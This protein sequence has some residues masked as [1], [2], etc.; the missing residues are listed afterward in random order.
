MVSTLLSVLPFPTATFTGARGAHKWHQEYN[1]S[2]HRVQ[3]SYQLFQKPRLDTNVGILLSLRHP[4]QPL[5]I[6]LLKVILFRSVLLSMI[7]NY[8]KLSCLIDWQLSVPNA[9]GHAYSSST[10]VYASVRG[11]KIYNE[12]Y[13]S[14]S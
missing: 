1:Y 7:L 5:L 14:H 8:K 13:A 3:Y 4:F 2:Y 6:S 10:V 12:Q 9:N 11:I